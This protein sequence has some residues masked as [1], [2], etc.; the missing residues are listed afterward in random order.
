MKADLV[1]A[2]GNKG[3]GVIVANA[4]DGFWWK[5]PDLVNG[6]WQNLGEDA[7]N[8]GMTVLIQ[9]GTSSTFDPGDINGIDDDGN[10]KVDDMK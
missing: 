6:I 2:L 9:S 4:D 3:R 10:G 5:H 8:N 1:W 7:N